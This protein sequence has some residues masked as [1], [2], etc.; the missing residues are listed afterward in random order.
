M[1]LSI[2]FIRQSKDEPLDLKEDFIFMEDIMIVEVFTNIEPG[3][4]T[5]NHH[6]TY[7]IAASKLVELLER[8]E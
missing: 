1:K 5:S 6:G 4:S 7:E 8:D 3:V 2:E